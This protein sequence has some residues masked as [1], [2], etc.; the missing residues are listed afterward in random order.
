MAKLATKWQAKDG[1]STVTPENAGFSLLLEDGFTLLLETDDELLLEDNVVTAKNAS[2]WTDPSKQSTAWQ[3]KDGFSTIQPG[4]SETLTTEA[5]EERLT[6][7]GDA[8]VTEDV[9]LTKKNPTEWAND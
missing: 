2:G 7:A 4:V 1:F 5:D 6:E 8:R 9:S 3:A